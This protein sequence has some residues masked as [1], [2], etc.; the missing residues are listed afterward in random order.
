VGGH[1]DA[2]SL[3]AMRCHTASS[4]AALV[5]NRGRFNE[6]AQL[7]ERSTPQV[8]FCVSAPKLLISRVKPEGRKD[9]LFPHP[10]VV[11]TSKGGLKHTG[12]SE[13]GADRFSGSRG[14]SGEQAKETVPIRK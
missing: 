6:I 10:R 13:L 1:A 14:S 11:E 2:E 3:T 4:S 9:I 5:T 7:L 8:D 12:V